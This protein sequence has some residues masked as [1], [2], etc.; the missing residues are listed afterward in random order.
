LRDELHEEAFAAGL[1]ILGIEIHARGRI[2]ENKPRPPGFAGQ[3]PVTALLEKLE[4]E[5]EDV[6]KIAI[7][8][9]HKPTSRPSWPCALGDA[10]TGI[11][12]FGDDCH[13]RRLPEKRTE[14][15]RV[16]YMEV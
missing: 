4:F 11:T 7:I 13:A 1:A 9:G 12:D 10:V 14:V 16:E 8:P 2:F 15:L 3:S 6:K 5:L